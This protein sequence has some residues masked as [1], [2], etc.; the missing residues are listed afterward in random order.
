MI[1]MS[2]ITRHT[3]MNPLDHSYPCWQK[4]GLMIYPIHFSR[5]DLL[6]SLR[7]I[8]INSKTRIESS[9]INNKVVRLSKHD[10]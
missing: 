6:N 7:F 1:L 8:I 3:L 4:S 5:F 2:E 10:L 9:S